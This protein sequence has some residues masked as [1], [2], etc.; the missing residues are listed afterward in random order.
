MDIDNIDDN[1]L[2]TTPN[3]YSLKNSC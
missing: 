2:M 1:Q 3:K